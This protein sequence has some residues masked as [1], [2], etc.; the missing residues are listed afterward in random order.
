MSRSNR[1]ENADP[2]QWSSTQAYV[3]ALITLVIGFVS[4]YL[5]RGSGQTSGSGVSSGSVQ[6]TVSAPAAGKLGKASRDKP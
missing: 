5:F 3:L 4:G 2:S 6:I 1:P